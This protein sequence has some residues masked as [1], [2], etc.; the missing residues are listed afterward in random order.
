MWPCDMVFTYRTRGYFSHKLVEE[1]SL[2][3]V[4]CKI[5][6][7]VFDSADSELGCRMVQAITC[8]KMLYCS[9]LRLLTV[10]E[11]PRNAKKEWL[12]I[13]REEE[14][15]QEKNQEDTRRISILFN[16]GVIALCSIRKLGEFAWSEGLNVLSQNKF[17]QCV[18]YHIRNFYT[19]LILEGGAKGPVVM[20]GETVK[21]KSCSCCCERS[22]NI[23]L[24]I[25]R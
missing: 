16:L 3:S 6:R 1:H 12:I 7:R 9:K 23:K 14:N 22:V 2:C 19:H 11:N 25:Y 4:T 24:N 15:T 13:H 8:R 18:V 5:F 20:M 21:R 17:G 10:D